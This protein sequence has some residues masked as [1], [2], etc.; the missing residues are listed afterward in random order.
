[1]RVDG[2]DE[3]DAQLKSLS[4]MADA[5]TLIELGEDALQPVADAARGLV[6]QRTGRLAASIDVGH[7]LSPAQAAA[8]KPEPN[9]VEV[10]AGPGALPQAITEEFGTVHEQGHPYMRPA[11]DGNVGAVMTRL[12]KGAGDRLRGIVKG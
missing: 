6:R 8:N 3:M 2:L 12:A 4:E 10:Y 5:E 9:T 7:Q 1:M 11:W